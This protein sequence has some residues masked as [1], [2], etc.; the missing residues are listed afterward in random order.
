MTERGRIAITGIG[1]VTPLG[2]TAS[3]T[4]TAWQK[5]HVAK[6]K[7][8]EIFAGTALEDAEVAM[9]PD[10]DAATAI[11]NRRMLK[12]MS[13]T[14]VLGCMAA[15]ACLGES[16]ALAR[17]QP[18]RIGLYAA[19]GLASANLEEIEGIIAASVDERGELSERLLGERGLAVANPLLSF[20]ILANIPAC[21]I[22]IIEGIKG[23]NLIFTPWE[24]QTGA[25]IAEGLLAV[26][27]GMVDCALVGAAD[28]P[29]HPSTLAYLRQ[30]GFIGASEYS[31][32]GAAY[33]LLEREETARRDGMAI[34]AFI[35]EVKISAADEKLDDPL[36]ERMGR[37]Y[38]AAPAIMAA[39]A[40][41]TNLEGLSQIV[42]IDR[43]RVEI[44]L[45][46]V[47]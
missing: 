18:E 1:M 7:R 2:V 25:A 3:E 43:Q 46:A 30:E 41:M 15:H 24:A 5:G 29:A 47:R 16:A 6:R 19:T 14:A 4:A 28:N 13:D 31:A 35:N 20:K 8:L 32:P 10:F 26:E 36:S 37:T 38:A 44:R 17:F 40:A 9:L 45:E 22:S 12:Y 42:G 21:L 23:P 34:H 27:S 11:G 33:L 39:I